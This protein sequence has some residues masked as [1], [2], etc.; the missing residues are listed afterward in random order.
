MIPGKRPIPLAPAPARFGGTN[1][2]PTTAKAGPEPTM[3]DELSDT[4]SSEGET[5]LVA[6]TDTTGMYA[7]LENDEEE[8]EIEGEEHIGDDD[9]DRDELV[10]QRIANSQEQMK[11]ILEELDEEQLQRYETFRRVGLPRPMIKKVLLYY[12]FYIFNLFITLFSPSFT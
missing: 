5:Q 6:R 1:T 2:H 3:N 8:Y 12:S 11:N 4:S 10:R 7:E 9:V